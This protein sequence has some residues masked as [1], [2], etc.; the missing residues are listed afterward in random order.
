MEGLDKQKEARCDSEI[1]FHF[2]FGFTLKHK[3]EHKTFF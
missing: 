3:I 2:S 1:Q